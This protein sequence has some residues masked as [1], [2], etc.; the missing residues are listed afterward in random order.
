MKNLLDNDFVVYA[1]YPV[2]GVACQTISYIG[3]FVLKDNVACGNCQRMHAY[4]YNTCN[5]EN[6]YIDAVNAATL[7]NHEAFM[8]DLKQED[9]GVADFLLYTKNTIAFID[10]TCGFS[11]Y[12]E[13][14][15]TEGVVTQGKRVKARKQLDASI[16][17]LYQLPTIG[18]HL[19]S[20]QVKAGILGYRNIDEEMFVNVKSNLDKSEEAF[21]GMARELEMRSLKMPLSH[22]FSFQMVKYPQVFTIK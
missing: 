1:G 11:Q 2:G 19:D 7:I 4:F 17:R 16:N 5:Y 8:V 18:Q 9:G 3:P 22:G 21:M 14:H 15:E 6:M 13:P 12:L 10:L 20:Y